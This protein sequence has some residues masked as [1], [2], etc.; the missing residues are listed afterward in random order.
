MAFSGGGIL[1]A[2]LYPPLCF[3]EITLYWDCSKCEV[4]TSGRV[5]GYPV[6]ILTGFPIEV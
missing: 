4:K 3:N 2:S 1:L 6:F 5:Y